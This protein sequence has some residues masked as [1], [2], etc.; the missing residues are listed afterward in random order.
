[1]AITIAQNSVNILFGKKMTDQ[2][3]QNLNLFL[4]FFGG[5][6]DDPIE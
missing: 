3:R 2:N 4:K 5:T 1:M 6:L